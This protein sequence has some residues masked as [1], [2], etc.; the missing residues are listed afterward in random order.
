MH[1]KDRIGTVFKLIQRAGETC[2]TC[3][4]E[5]GSLPLSPFQNLQNKSIEALE[6]AIAEC[7]SAMTD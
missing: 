7:R 3:K 1:M 5:E 6:E 2:S 4:H